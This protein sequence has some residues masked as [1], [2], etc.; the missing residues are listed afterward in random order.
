MGT[1][2]MSLVWDL[3]LKPSRAPDDARGRA[4][5]ELAAA[6]ADGKVDLVRIGDLATIR[7]K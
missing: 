3:V 7:V 5:G 4:L 1:S 2:G 6:A